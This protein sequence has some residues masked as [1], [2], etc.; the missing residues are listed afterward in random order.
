MVPYRRYRPVRRRGLPAHHRPQERAA[1]A[2]Q[3]QEGGSRPH[4]AL[5]AGQPADRAGGGAGRQSKLRVRPGG[6]RARGGGR[7]AGPSGRPSVAG[8]EPSGPRAPDGRNRAPLSR[9][10]QLRAGQ[11]DRPLAPRADP[12][13]GRP[14]PHAQG[15]AP[16]R[17]EGLP[18][19]HRGPLPGV[20]QQRVEVWTSGSLATQQALFYRCLAT[21][22]N[23]SIHI[24]RALR[25]MAEQMEHPLFRSS[26]S[27]IARRVEGGKRRHGP[28]RAGLSPSAQPAGGPGRAD[29]QP[30]PDFGEAGP[31][32]WP[33]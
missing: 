12:G 18:S 15:Q 8:R 6:A 30:A 27:D 32:G 17:F 7:S 22:Y 2:L 16:G 3:R 29:R 31:P 4:R 25:I 21:L 24:T 23:S 28:A 10:V 26:L 9:P 19:H 5:A 14:D 1:G 11:E 33:C 13:G 20:T